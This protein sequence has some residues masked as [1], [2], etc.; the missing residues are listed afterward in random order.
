MSDQ[1]T[2]SEKFLEDSVR[3][4]ESMSASDIDGD[5]S[6]IRLPHVPHTPVGC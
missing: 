5:L 4:I 6:D 1:K 3:V 2:F